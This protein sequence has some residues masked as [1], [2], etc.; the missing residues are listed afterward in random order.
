[1]SEI[2]LESNFAL[3]K[4][5]NHLKTFGRHHSRMSPKNFVDNGNK[6]LFL[7]LLKHPHKFFNLSALK[8]QIIS[9]FRKIFCMREV[10]DVVRVCSFALPI[11]QECLISKIMNISRK[12]YSL[13]GIVSAVE[14]F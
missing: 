1:M 11:S 10:N 8:L 13:C 7:L 14:M 5:Q 4:K 12:V 9:C 2:S 6:I 3:E